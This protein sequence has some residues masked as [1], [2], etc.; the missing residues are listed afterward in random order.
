VTPYLPSVSSNRNTL[1]T[2]LQ[3]MRDASQKV[4]SFTGA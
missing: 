4:V 3:N 1:V 2:T